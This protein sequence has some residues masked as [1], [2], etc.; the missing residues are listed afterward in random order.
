MMSSVEA[1]LSSLSGGGHL[2]CGSQMGGGGEAELQGEGV[3]AVCGS[4]SKNSLVK[5]SSSLTPGGEDR[6]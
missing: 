2:V 4:E 5:P 6:Y 3:G 1:L